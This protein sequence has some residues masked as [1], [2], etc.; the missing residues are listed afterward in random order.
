MQWEEKSCR[1]MKVWY[2][3]LGWPAMVGV[4]NKAMMNLDYLWNSNVPEN[5]RTK[6]KTKTIPKKNILLKLK[7]DFKIRLTWFQIQIMKLLW[8]LEAV[9]WRCSV[10]KVFL[11]ISQNSLENTCARV[12]FL[13]KL[14]AGQVEIV[15]WKRSLRIENLTEMKWNIKSQLKNKRSFGALKPLLINGSYMFV[16]IVFYKG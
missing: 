1:L 3:V 10:K 2:L 14:Q 13:V 9:V 16:M 8:Y 12:P 7:F 15:S 11:E 5:S 6:Y 4:G